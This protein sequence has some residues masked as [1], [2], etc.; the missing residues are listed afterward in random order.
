M[1][2]F[3]E[4]SSISVV[5]LLTTKAEIIFSPSV[6]EETPGDSETGTSWATF[7]PLQ[8]L[9]CDLAGAFLLANY[10]WPVDPG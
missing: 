10:S 3:P 5:R 8:R 4:I 1:L 2:S 6:P 7:C 9:L